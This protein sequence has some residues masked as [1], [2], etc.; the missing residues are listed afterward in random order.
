MGGANDAQNAQFGVSSTE[1]VLGDSFPQ[2]QLTTDVVRPEPAEA[3]TFDDE[4]LETV[5]DGYFA[6]NYANE[7]SDW[8]N[9]PTARHGNAGV[10]GFVDGHS[11]LWHWRRL[12]K[13]QGLNTSWSGPPNTQVDFIR[14][15]M[16]VFRL[17]GQP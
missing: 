3:M 2:Y 9:S 5:D 17:A 10:F 7:P 13:D 14:C 4:S 16:A 1:W 15:Q 6:I 11:E 12:S 8:Q